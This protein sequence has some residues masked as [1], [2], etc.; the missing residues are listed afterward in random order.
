MRRFGLRFSLAQTEAS[1]RSW[2]NEQNISLIRLAGAVTIPA[3]LGCPIVGYLWQ[4]DIDWFGIW[5]P[6]CSLVIPVVVLALWSS[7]TR[8]RRY[9][10]Q[11]V[12]AILA[13]A[14]STLLW[15]TAVR[16][17]A[18]PG[19]VSP[20]GAAAAMMVMAS[21]ALYTRL[22]PFL[23]VTSIAPFMLALMAWIFHSVRSGDFP[24]EAGYLPVTGAC[25][26]YFFVVIMS[27][28][29]ERFLRRTFVSEQLLAQRTLAL[30]R[31]RDLIRRYVPS[32]LAEHIIDDWQAD[33]GAP[34]RQRV[35]VL[36][37]DI[38]GFTEIADRVEP[39]VLTQIIGEY[40]AAMAGIAEAFNG[41][42]NEFTGDGL[43]ALFGAPRRLEA[44]EQV[45]CAVDAAL[46]MQGRLP[47]LNAGWRRLGLG[48]PL[49]M[50]IGIN[51]GML[52]V[53]SYGSAGR[54]TYTAIGLQTNIAARIQ[55]HCE[56]GR[57]LV[58]QSTSA[59]MQDRIPRIDRGEISLKGVHYP[60]RV[61]EVSGTT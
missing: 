35:T 54:M 22:P 31:S 53:G 12:A 56:P 1:Y 43:M 10:T 24:P 19:L 57:I 29:G 42:V 15:I 8:L 9:A 11:A 44:E 49:Q 58:S 41:T 47:E 16:M 32:A 55:A 25:V 30:E 18:I 37:A 26:T 40:M 51:T 21:F 6:G 27:V 50:R 4:R 38:K 14:G 20:G 7:W 45:R 46:A 60:V 3:W 2:R 5:T 17:S 33:V 34:R 28:A 61:Y 36:F 39:E 59:L 48:E 23:A 13:I 52:S